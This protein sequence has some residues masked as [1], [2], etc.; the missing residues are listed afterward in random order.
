MSKENP[1]RLPSSDTQLVEVAMVDEEMAPLFAGL[2]AGDISDADVTRGMGV[3]IY[4][5]FILEHTP[6]LAVIFQMVSDPMHLPAVFHCELGKD[7]TPTLWSNG[8][9]VI[10]TLTRC[11]LC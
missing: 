8:L 7:R 6:K 10:P 3:Q 9:L 2:W 11:D 1:D 4:D 5:S